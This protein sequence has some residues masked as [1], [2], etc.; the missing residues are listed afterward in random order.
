M[1]VI[2]FHSHILP[3][4]DDGSQNIETSLQMLKESTLQGVDIMMATPHF[5]ASKDRIE[6]FL[7]RRNRAYDSL[8]ST[9]GENL[10]PKLRLGAEVAF[11]P[12]ISGAAKIDSL[13][14]QGTRLLLLEM[15]F[16]SWTTS[17]IREVEK[18]I[19]KRGF[20]IILAHLERY[21]GMKE[22]KKKIEELRQMPLYVQIN[23]GSLLDW[24]KRR[25]LLKMFQ[26]GEAH[27]LGSDCHG[28]NHR[29]PN[30]AQGREM[31]NKKIGK[32]ALERLDIL[33][34]KLIMH[35]KV[36]RKLSSS[37]VNDGADGIGGKNV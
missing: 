29:A 18:M 5:Y 17:D 35:K 33:G 9:L 36:D 3:G 12:G 14:F 19:D 10:Q 25:I 13:V 27:L 21:M 28:I 24:K 26:K 2:D 6:D 23:A 20:Q 32:G 34:N 1:E 31:L 37:L 30:L 7:K 11:F 22:N 4:I 15:P 8:R 16:R